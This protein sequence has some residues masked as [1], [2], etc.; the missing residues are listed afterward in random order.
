MIQDHLPSFLPVPSSATYGDNHRDWLSLVQVCRK[1]RDTAVASPSLWSTIDNATIPNIFLERSLTAPLTVYLGIR[2]PLILNNV[3]DTLI[4]HI[5]RFQQFHLNLNGCSTASPLAVLETFDMPAPN[6][7]SLTIAT[8]SKEGVNVVLP[9]LFGGQ[10]PRLTQLTLEHFTSWPGNSFHNLTHLCL[11]DQSEIGRQS[12]SEFLDL[13]ESCPLLQRLNLVQAGP[14][15]EDDDDP[16]VP[17]SRL[18]SMTYLR[19]LNI[20]DWPSA[21]RIARFLSHLILPRETDMYLWGDHLLGDSEDITSLIPPNFSRL[22]NLTNVNELFFI[23]QTTL[24]LNVPLVAVVGSVLYM[25]GSFKPQQ[26]PAISQGYPL[27]N[28]EHLQIRD[29]YKHP[30]RLPMETWRN[31]FKAMPSLLTL[32]VFSWNSS[33]STRAILSALRHREGEGMPCPILHTLSIED[34]P[35]LPSLLLSTFA[36]ERTAYQSPLQKLYVT[37]WDGD[38]EEDDDRDDDDVPKLV[39]DILSLK[40]HVKVVEHEDKEPGLAVV[41][42]LSWPNPAFDW[43]RR[44]RFLVG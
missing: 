41:I 27:S 39:D 1:W 38:E 44:R 24:H 13:L 21:R 17:L 28:V 25:Y 11:Y 10:T 29:N 42:P 16:L 15:R 26:V 31:F 37:F 36:E 34:D 43:S 19:E 22:T 33:R 20:G 35:A 30:N 2:K 8:D 5:S 7:E 3:V 14:T 4:P 6:L 32:R 40:R 9:T 12:T 23:R 18:V